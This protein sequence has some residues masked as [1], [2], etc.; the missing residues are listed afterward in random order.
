MVAGKIGRKQTGRQARTGWTDELCCCALVTG[1]RDGA[2]AINVS[3]G[4]ILWETESRWMKEDHTGHIQFC[5]DVGLPANQTALAQH[6]EMN[7]LVEQIAGVFA[8]HQIHATW[9]LHQP[10]DS[11]T[12]VSILTADPEHELA[13]LG[14]EQ[15][16]SPDLGRDAI[17]QSLTESVQAAADQKQP[18]Q[19]MV[20]RDPAPEW[21]YPVISKWGIRTLRP[22]VERRVKGAIADQVASRIHGMAICQA[23]GV[24][25]GRGRLLG[26]FDLAY[27][28]KKILQRA[29]LKTTMEHLAID[30]S[31][32]M[33]HPT[34]SLRALDQ[35][36]FFANR[37]QERESVQ[38]ET[39]T[40]TTA[41][42]HPQSEE[43]AAASRP[44]A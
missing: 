15:W 43:H 35:I 41:R 36:L 16:L 27:R 22:T 4:Q 13:W 40:Q 19:T 44:A 38:I 6:R 8:R 37:M 23:T 12:A 29:Y 28:G 25:P 31:A 17:L 1:N 26:R 2:G 33:V 32:M 5:V 21:L 11:V 7:L 18:F 30:A 14:C 20:L 3:A 24:F 34:A 39:L 9:A 42:W 10:V